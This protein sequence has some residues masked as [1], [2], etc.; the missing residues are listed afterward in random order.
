MSNYD[1]TNKGALFKNEKQNERQPDLR[2]PANVDG[3]EYEISAW[4]KESQNA[5]KYYSLSIQPR[6]VNGGSLKAKE[7]SNEDEIMPF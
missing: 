1:N 6:K 3:K 4:I 7:S 5:G 2:G